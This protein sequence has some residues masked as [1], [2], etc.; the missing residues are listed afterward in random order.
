M[1]ARRMAVL[2]TVLG[3]LLA[4]FEVTLPLGL[5]IRFHLAEAAGLAAAYF[6]GGPLGGAL[7]GLI[8]GSSTFGT[9]WL[10]NAVG[11][12]AA[13]GLAGWAF[14][15][16][17]RKARVIFLSQ[18]VLAVTVAGAL[19]LNEWDGAVFAGTALT[20]VIALLPGALIMAI[21]FKLTWWWTSLVVATGI[22]FTLVARAPLFP[23]AAAVAPVEGL[24]AGVAVVDVTP[25]PGEEVFLGGYSGRSGPGRGEPLDP[26]TLRVLVLQEGSQR[27]TF[28]AMDT[29]GMGSNL[30]SRLRAAAG[31]GDVFLSSSHSHSAPDLQGL[32]GGADPAYEDRL[33][34]AARSATSEAVKSMKPAVL[35]TATGA[36]PLGIQ[37]NR[38]GWEMAFDR[39]NTLRIT[40]TDGAPIATLANFALHPTVLDRGNARFSADFV[41]VM[42]QVAEAKLGGKV[43]FAN[44]ALGDIVPHAPDGVE[45]LGRRLGEEV[46]QVGR[47]GMAADSPKLT[48]A[49]EALDLPLSNWKFQVAWSVGW[50]RYQQ[51][52]AGVVPVMRTRVSVIHLGDVTLLTAPGEVTTRLARRLEGADFLLGLTHDSLGYL[53]PR[54]E[55]QTGRNENYEESVSLGPQAGERYAAAAR[56]LLSK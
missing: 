19:A 56:R 40:T 9:L 55:W 52:W 32:W 15:R 30:A 41:G 2:F 17:G 36:L 7:V 48:V 46:A 10:P 54:D 11:H 26:I 5:G 1:F 27:V 20:L 8:V 23:E 50:L 22:A 24:H 13:L 31:A 51:A 45:A 42:R 53:I 18:G 6:A 44:G 21:P 49:H 29:V 35:N 47:L 43:L 39:I 14:A 12:A 16:W 4:F 38:R 33:V 3:W 25:T 34:E 28:L 37:K